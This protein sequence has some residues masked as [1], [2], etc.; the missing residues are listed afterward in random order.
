MSIFKDTVTKSENLKLLKKRIL[1]DIVNKGIFS[2]GK[3]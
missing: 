3:Y 2:F 1:K